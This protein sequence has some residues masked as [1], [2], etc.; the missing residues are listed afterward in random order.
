M[1][2]IPFYMTQKEVHY[3]PPTP[4]KVEIEGEKNKF[5]IFTFILFHY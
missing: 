1:M 2:E 3:G 4:G 5:K